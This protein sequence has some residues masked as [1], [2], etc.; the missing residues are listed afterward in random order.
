MSKQVCTACSIYVAATK[1]KKKIDHG[2]GCQ[3]VSR[4]AKEVKQISISNEVK[5]KLKRRETM[6]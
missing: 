1:I 6:V 3:Y 2:I 5:R 4:T